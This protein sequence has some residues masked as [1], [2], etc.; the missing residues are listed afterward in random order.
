M[1][2]PFLSDFFESCLFRRD[3]ELDEAAEFSD[4]VED[5]SPLSSLF[6]DFPLFF[7]LSVIK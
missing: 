2:S 1:E 3:S 5:S 6:L 7:D 4:D